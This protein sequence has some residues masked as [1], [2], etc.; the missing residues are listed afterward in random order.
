MRRLS[1]IVCFL[2]FLATAFAQEAKIPSSVHRVLILGDSITYDGKYV[3]DIEAYFV[4][5]YPNREIEFIN[6]GL[7]SETVSGLSEEGHAGGQ[8]PRPDLHERLARVLTQTK[9]DLVF[10]CYG[11]NDGIYQPF[12][13]GR[14]QKF[15]DG[16]LW[17]HEQVTKTGAPILHVSPPVY[18]GRGRNTN[19]NAVL[20]RYSEWL[21]GQ[22][23]AA[24]WDVADVHGPMNRVLETRIAADPKFK[25]ANDGVHPDAFGHWIIAQAILEHLGAQDVANLNSPE[26]MVANHPHGAELLKLI[27]QRQAMMK[28]AWLTATGHKRPGMNKGLPLAEAQSKY[29]ETEHEI[30]EL[31]K[32]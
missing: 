8:F 21:L 7:P 17:L 27:Q 9:P 14:F 25:F 11:M 30:H 2:A 32:H 12:D 31:S 29:A 10:A 4:T 22:R 18:D 19:Y 6:V 28:D 1:L 15:K 23:A 26:E 3:S 16:M 20:D 13:E 5:R 24:G